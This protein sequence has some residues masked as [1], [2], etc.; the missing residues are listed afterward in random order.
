MGEFA[1]IPDVEALLVN[2]LL[3]HATVAAMVSTKVSTEL[4]TT[5]PDGKRLKLSRIGGTPVD[6]DTEY[7]D[8]PLIQLEGFG[9]TKADAFDVTAAAMTALLSFAGKTYTE[10]TVTKVLRLS[11]PAYAQDPDT[12]TPRYLLTV[13]VYVHA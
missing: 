13:A 10:G 2:A 7:L 5:F 6:E 9:A 1:R 4:P 8:R 3:A 11:G 12:E